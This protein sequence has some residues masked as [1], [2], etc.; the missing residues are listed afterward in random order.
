MTQWEIINLVRNIAS[1]EGVD[2]D[3]AAAICTVESNAMYPE[4]CC[5]Y[6]KNYAYITESKR[7]AF[8]NGITEDTEIQHQKMSWGPM[9]VMGGVA[10]ELGFTEP[11]PLLMQPAYGVYYGI[12]KLKELAAKYENDLSVIAAYNAGSAR[13]LPGKGYVNQTYVDKVVSYLPKTRKF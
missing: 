2:P 4:R 6:E 9:H 12:L 13:K 11:L 8:K 5:R 3:I 7:H 1:R 10:R